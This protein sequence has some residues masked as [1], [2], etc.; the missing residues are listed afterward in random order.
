[1]SQTRNSGAGNRRK[2]RWIAFGF[3]G[4]FATSVFTVIYTGLNVEGSRAEFDAGFRSVILTIGETRSV[5]LQFESSRPVQDA[6]LAVT[7]PDV[8]EFAEPSDRSGAIPVQEVVGGANSISVEIRAIA[9]GSGYLEARL[10]G[11]EPIGLYRVFLT[12]SDEQDQ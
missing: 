3:L 5:E 4:A 11:D 12:V 9:A 1:M 6:T 8:V 7:L 10:Q 2:A